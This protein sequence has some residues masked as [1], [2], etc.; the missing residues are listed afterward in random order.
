MIDANAFGF[1]RAAAVCAAVAVT[2]LV[3]VPTSTAGGDESLDSVLGEIEWGD[4]KETVLEKLKS[5]MLAELR[6]N[7]EFER[8]RVKL[9][10]ARKRMMDKLDRIKQSYTELDG[11]T[12]YDVSVISGEFTPN[13]NEA[14]LKIND[15]AAQR[16]FFFADGR[17]YKM[18]VA[19]RESYLEG[20]SFKSFIGQ[21][22]N[23]YGGPDDTSS[24]EIGGENKL[25]TATWK[26]RG[27]LLEAKNK[28]E[29]FGTLAMVFSDRQR[30]EKMAQKEGAFG[31]SEKGDDSV[32][33]RVEA[34]KKDSG[35]DENENVV[36]SMVGEEV[37]VDISTRQEN[38]SEQGPAGQ[39][40]RAVQDD[41]QQESEKQAESSTSSSGG[42]S[43]GQDDQEEDRDFSN[44]SADEKQESGDDDELIVY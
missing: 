43:S 31:G 36:D 28:R 6:Q 30:V 21:V 4:S 41:E 37:E 8:D 33:N 34:L 1:R 29:I 38:V 26:S 14:L 40:E 2:L 10:E 35:A 32:S 23:K 19:Y 42:S 17:V 12:G 27:T 44:L 39:S 11:D 22:S 5:E 20:V 9:Q 18:V 3:G 25:A 13:N 16:F 7:D 24:R 15:E